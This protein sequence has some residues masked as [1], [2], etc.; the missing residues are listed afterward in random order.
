MRLGIQLDVYI[1]LVACTDTRAFAVLGTDREHE[2][3][4]HR[5]DG[6]SIAVVVDRDLHGWPLCRSERRHDPGRD[7]NTEATLDPNALRSTAMNTNSRRRMYVVLVIAAV[8]LVI[9]QLTKLGAERALPNR[10]P[11]R[12]IGDFLQL[13]LVYNPGAAFSIGSGST[14]VFTILAGAAVVALGWIATRV[15][16]RGWAIA[17]GLLL[18]GAST[19]LLDRLFRAPGFALGHV[20]DFID[21]NGWFVGNIADIALTVG[22]ALLIVLSLRGTD[23]K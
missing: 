2:L 17:M 13:R 9:D 5:R 16:S 22:A 15:H 3:P 21:Y 8:V 20:V 23:F 14:W 7:L 19:H 18:G 1:H 10:A 6:A 12:L 4:A 11:I